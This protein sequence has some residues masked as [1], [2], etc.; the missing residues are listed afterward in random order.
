MALATV[1]FDAGQPVDLEASLLG[2]QAHRWKREGEWYSGVLR[3]DFV[4][5]RL[6]PGHSHLSPGHSREGGNPSPEIEFLSNSPD[7]QAMIA[8]I[9]EHLRLDDD[10]KAIQAE[11]AGDPNVA[12][13]VERYPGLRVLRQEPWECLVAYICSANSNIE[14]IHRNMERLSDEF[15]DPL[16]LPRPNSPSPLGVRE[17]VAEEETITRHTFPQP[18]DLAEAGEAELRRLKLGFRAPYVHQAAIAVAEKRLDLDYLVAAPY[19]EAK[20]E[21]M[22]LKGIGDKIADCIA[23]MSLEKMEA[24]P[25]DVWVRRALADWYFPPEPGS[26]GQK[27]PANRVLLEWAQGY[28]GRYAGYANQYLFHGRRLRDRKEKWEQA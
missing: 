10:L 12:A 16:T 6:S 2:G 15:G 21:L 25:I 13:Q 23:L 5:V 11:I 7:S 26:K 4:L 1:R 22:A 9:R 3:G 14:T 27:T 18:V 8:K 28:F 24:F 17:E 20:A 19:P